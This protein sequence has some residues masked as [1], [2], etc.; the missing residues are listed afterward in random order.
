MVPNIG[1]VSGQC[2]SS[3]LHSVYTLAVG[4]FTEASCAK[5]RV[6]HK[7]I[8]DCPFH[9]HLNTISVAVYKR[10]RN[11]TSYTY[12]VSNVV[13][14]HLFHK[15]CKAGRVHDSIYG[16]EHCFYAWIALSSVF[17]LRAASI[18]RWP[19]CP[20]PFFIK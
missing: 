6:I 20:F 4:F 11:N 17:T 10:V 15:L 9:R 13:V 8:G 16:Y 7:S 2:H 1:Y 3:G 14:L 18:N 5:N 19:H 12:N